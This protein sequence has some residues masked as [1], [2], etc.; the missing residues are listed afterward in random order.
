MSNEILTLAGVLIAAAQ[1]AVMIKA[2][3]RKQR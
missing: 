1:L 2:L 3:N